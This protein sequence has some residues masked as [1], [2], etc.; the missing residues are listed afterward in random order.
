M[1]FEHFAN[2]P[3][4]TKLLRLQFVTVGLALI[5]V[6][7][8]SI[9]T[10]FWQE[11]QAMLDDLTST[12]N[13]I[14]FNASAALL[15]DDSLSANTILAALHSKTNII[16]AQI[17][18]SQG[19]PYASYFA[20]ERLIQLPVDLV[21]AEQQV[22][23]DSL[24][25]LTHVVI[26][27]IKKDEETVGFLYLLI[28]LKPMWFGLMNKIG[29]I[30]LVMLVALLFS[31]FLGRRLAKQI[32]LPLIRLAEIAEEMSQQKKYNLRAS[33]EGKDEVGLL[34]KSFNQ[35]IEQ[36][37]QR[38][39]ELA[40]HRDKLEEEVELRTRDL[41]L[42]VGEAQAASIAKSQFLAT[43]SHEIRTPMNG[44][45]GM[46]E[47]L[48]DTQL[49]TTQRRFTEMLQK[50]GESLL[51]II[52]DILDFSKIEAGHFELESL[53][54]SLYQIIENIVE[55]FA[56]SALNKGLELNYRIATEVPNYVNGD[57]TRLRQILS[58]LVSNA[59]KFTEHGEIL[60]DVRLADNT[61]MVTESIDADR[62]KVCFAVQDTGIG[63]HQEVLPRLF[64]SFSQ[65]DSSTTRNYGGT[66]L[67]LAI[68]K[69]LVE[70]MGGEI[71]VTSQI[72]FGSMFTCI[73]PISVSKS[74][75]P[76]HIERSGRLQGLSLLIVEDNTINRDILYQHALSW[77]MK[78]EAVASAL[79]AMEL[80]KLVLDDGTSGYDLIVIDM[81]MSDM[82][83]LELAR[84]IKANAELAHIPL[85][86]LTSLMMK[87]LAE[88]AKKAGFAAYLTKPLYK[89]ELYKALSSVL[90]AK[91]YSLTDQNIDLS[92][93]EKNTF[94][95]RLL[96]AEDNLV[97]LEL[98][99]E[100]LQRFGY[101]VDIA[102]N[103]LEALQA[104]EHNHYDLV[105]MDCMMP[106]MDGFVAT[107][108]I[109]RQ[110]KA[111]KLSPFPII[112]LTANVIEGDQQE[113][114]EI[115]M[116]DYL[117][118]PFKIEALVN[119]INFWL[120]A[121]EQLPKHEAND[122]TKLK[123]DL[124]INEAVLDTIC[125][126]DPKH[127]DELLCSL[128]KLYLANT[129]TILTKLEQAWEQGDIDGI[130]QACHTLKSSSHQLGAEQLANLCREVENEARN[131][132]YD[133]SGE[134]LMQI[135]QSFFQTQAILTRYLDK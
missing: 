62:L 106:V 73:V 87:D 26:Q 78:V 61:D 130:R 46:A 84:H 53:E 123:G 107:V 119:K 74:T 20:G 32:S 70:L 17:Y 103:G 69:Q 108:E 71:G 25:T 92:P 121:A 36:V 49:T 29:Q 116:D 27:A 35:M 128:I 122:L 104:I 86:M 33:G 85:V 95:G 65:A 96:L 58:N 5:F 132:C 126:L 133:I 56:E 77:G 34:V 51:A 54:F 63:I 100:I 102:H 15:F 9:A 52:N 90:A 48:L 39:F 88:E 89:A 28:D 120:N 6:L 10:Q 18:T 24:L 7:V 38:D 127:G 42:A 76:S 72:G 105:L 93:V 8:V 59:I 111:G 67:G 66:G 113:C 4:T 110:Q 64:Q 50:S 30:S 16:A 23:N 80:L 99:T 135:K 124:V 125:K 83:G 117:S 55:L 79:S 97:N 118:K 98:T 94:S 1:K 2:L 22:Q 44:V 91:N 37:Q 12:G 11:R 21:A 45:L 131:H 114:L 14:S 134:A 13:M 109:R 112:A 41:R 40:K 81:K 75:L 43:M 19:V 57:P 31:L 68:C 101:S 82:N 47:L 115:G 129:D 3:I 60:I